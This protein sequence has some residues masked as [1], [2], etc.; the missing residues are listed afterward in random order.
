[1][2]EK[3]ECFEHSGELAGAKVLIK[4]LAKPLKID[5]GGID[6]LEKFSTRLRRDIARTHCDS[7]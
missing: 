6:V 2:F 1:V 3:V 7:L 5:I 4:P